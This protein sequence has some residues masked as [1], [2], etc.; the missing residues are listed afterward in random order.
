MQTD[1]LAEQGCGPWTAQDGL[2]IVTSLLRAMKSLMKKSPVGKQNTAGQDGLLHIG[3]R[4]FVCVF[5]VS[6]PYM[7]N[8]GG[9]G[10][11]TMNVLSF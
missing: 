11:L 8:A 9:A 5:V 6:V 3:N 1:A 4:Y 10:T 7:E 2:E